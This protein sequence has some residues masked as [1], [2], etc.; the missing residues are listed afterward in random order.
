MDQDYL[1]EWVVPFYMN[2]LHGNYL[3]KD[4]KSTEF[5]TKVEQ[6]IQKITPEIVERLIEGYWRESITGS[7]F[8]GLKKY[9][10]FQDR[11]GDLLIASE[12]VYAGQSHAFALAN[13]SNKKSGEYLSQYLDIYLSQPNLVYDQDW[14]MV[15]LMW[16]DSQNETALASRFLVPN[17][18]WD[19]Y[20]KDKN[21]QSWSIERRKNDFW[22]V[23]NYCLTNFKTA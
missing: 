6:A 23:M 18:L 3:R 16:V 14:V 13:F 9:T 20:T 4:I 1:N 8:A 5:N 12:A 22:E 15:A 2:I 11:I 19:Q 21:S 10:Q 7:W 17:G